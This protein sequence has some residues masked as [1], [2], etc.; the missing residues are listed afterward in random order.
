ME[1]E[2]LLDKYYSTVLTIT[3]KPVFHHYLCFVVILTDAIILQG[4][5]GESHVCVELRVLLHDTDTR[6][7]TYR[8]GTDTPK[9]VQVQIDI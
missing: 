9:V 1:H 8:D 4:G 3:L 7:T 6:V 2:K 5:G